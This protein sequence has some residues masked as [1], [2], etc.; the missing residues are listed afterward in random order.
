MKRI[1]NKKEEH[2]LNVAVYGQSGTGK[3]SLGVTCPRPLILA[4]ERQA[5]LSVE[6][7][8]QRLGLSEVPIVLYMEDMSDYRS[9]VRALHGSTDEPLTI[10]NK[11]GDILLE[12]E[13][14]ETVVLDSL[15]D[16]GAMI[17]RDVWTKH[18]PKPDR[19]TGLP[20]KR[21]EHWGMISDRLTNLIQ[22]FRDVPV[23]VLFLCLSDDREEDERRGISRSVR[24]QLSP[25]KM[26]DVLTASCNLVGYTYRRESK[27]AGVV[28]MVFAT[29]F[30]GPE[31]FLLK[32]CAPLRNCENSDFSTWEKSI[33]DH[34]V[35]K[36]T[37]PVASSE[38]ASSDAP[39][40]EPDVK[41]SKSTKKK[42][43][44]K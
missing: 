3:T 30:Q 5:M 33:R 10:K 15:T 35:P 8:A 41:S 25:K 23:N 7:A 34:V 29:M 36:S 39:A 26:A 16:A 1:D 14:P 24:P 40:Q 38:S 44:T 2:F 13:W 27:K 18:P 20:V 42:K 37:Q 22:S 12:C 31:A 43:E 11:E 32:S 9:V 28:K 19:E 17:A 21:F 4:S 6:Q